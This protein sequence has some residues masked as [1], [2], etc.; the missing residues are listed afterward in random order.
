MKGLQ[1]SYNK[2]V[3]PS[4]GIIRIL[5]VHQGANLRSEIVH[6]YFAFQSIGIPLEAPVLLGLNTCTCIWLAEKRNR[7]CSILLSSFQHCGMVKKRKKGYY[8]FGFS[9][10]SFPNCLLNEITGR[11][12]VFFSNIVKSPGWTSLRSSDSCHYKFYA[13]IALFICILLSLK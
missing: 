13:Q 10:H 7:K 2:A 6:L 8:S 11:T 9:S 4:M 5:P 3:H 12:P 1:S